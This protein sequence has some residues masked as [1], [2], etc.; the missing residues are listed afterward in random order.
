MMEIENLINTSPFSN[1]HLKSVTGDFSSLKNLMFGFSGTD[2]TD[3]SGNL[4]S[5]KMAFYPFNNCTKLNSFT[6]DTSSLFVSTPDALNIQTL[7]FWLWIGEYIAPFGGFFAHS[8]IMSFN[9]DLDNL[10]VGGG[11][12]YNC[13]NLT[14]FQSDLPSLGNFGKLYE[15]DEKLEF[16]GEM[17]APYPPQTEEDIAAWND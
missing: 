8:K 4:S 11:M 2:I 1:N 13:K 7:A 16:F 17:P 15:T 5:L 9:S 10:V 6:G 14:S 3:F 12:F